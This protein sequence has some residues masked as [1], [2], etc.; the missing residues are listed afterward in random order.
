MKK[1]IFKFS[2]LIFF[3]VSVTLINVNNKNKGNIT[4]NN[5]LVATKNENIK[6]ERKLY[7][8]LEPK[9]S[10]EV[11]LKDETVVI[12]EN[13]SIKSTDDKVTNLEEKI[14]EEK[15]QFYEE[16]EDNDNMTVNLKKEEKSSVLENNVN[17]DNLENNEKNMDIN[18]LNS[19]NI[20]ESKDEDQKK[21]SSLEKEKLNQT[22]LQTEEKNDMGDIKETLVEEKKEV[23]L[24]NGF[25]TENNETYYYENDVKVKGLKNI[26][27]VNEYFSPSGVYLGN[28][29]VKVIDVS[30][31]QGTINW[32]LFA[33]KAKVYGVILRVGYWNTLDRE[34]VNNLNSLK[35]LNIPYGI[36]L[37]SYATTISGAT[38]EANFVSKIIKQYQVEPSLGIYYDLES[39]K[40]KNS[41]SDKISKKR[42]DDMVNTFVGIIKNNVGTNYKIGVYS[43]RWYAMNR[44][45]STAKSYVDW[46]AEYNKTCKYDSSYSMW[47]YTSKG[48]VPGVNGNVDISYLR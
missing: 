20:V 22:I 31:H 42:Y 23:L 10:D 3:L 26:N 28:N 27:G 6:G 36:Y 11:T 7:V 33:S 38:T 8:C 9:I 29:N 45:G 4:K 15:T 12:S 41:S 34:F 30:H 21:E 43:G 47:Q 44:L 5:A 1:K 13:T 25:I 35:R 2:V 18:I 14:I 46:V 48:S 17:N 37:Y 19:D 39:W 40:T 24:K 16:K 32:D